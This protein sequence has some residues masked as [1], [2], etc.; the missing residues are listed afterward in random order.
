[1]TLAE[2]I[3]HLPVTREKLKGRRGLMADP[4]EEMDQVFDRLLGRSLLRGW[5]HPREWW[6]FESVEGGALARV[7]VAD[8]DNEI[9]VRAEMPG[10]TKDDLDIS[11]SDNAITLRG[12]IKEE[13][14]EEKEG[15]YYY[16]KETGHGEFVRTLSLPA[17]VDG[18]KAKATFKNGVLNLVLPKMETAKRQ[19]IQIN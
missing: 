14:H 1:M 16:Y 10:V 12:T 4:F 8:R 7:D 2:K 18:T 3:R 19:K 6:P 11:L 5:M 9:V 13:E 17:A 15:E